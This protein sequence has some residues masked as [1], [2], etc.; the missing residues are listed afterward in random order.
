VMPWNVLVKVGRS[1]FHA[2]RHHEINMKTAS[3]TSSRL[4]DR[5]SRKEPRR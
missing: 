5:K 2:N 3:F 1:L 4:L